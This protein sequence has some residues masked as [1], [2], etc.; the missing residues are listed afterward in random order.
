[1]QSGWLCMFITRHQFMF[2]RRRSLLMLVTVNHYLEIYTSM[3]RQHS[4]WVRLLD[5]AGQYTLQVCSVPSLLHH[6]MIS[7]WSAG[8]A[9]RLRLHEEVTMRHNGVF[10]SQSRQVQKLNDYFS[11]L[12]ITCHHLGH[13]HGMQSVLTQKTKGVGK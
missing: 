6:L 2:S 5:K 11:H 3:E 9:L 10:S 13:H 4:A 7:P 8:P 12:I 1:M